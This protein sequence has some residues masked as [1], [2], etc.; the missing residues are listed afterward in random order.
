MTVGSEISPGDREAVF[1]GSV[2]GCQDKMPEATRQRVGAAAVLNFCS[3]YAKEIALTIT[4]E[5]L[6]ALADWSRPPEAIPHYLETARN[7]SA[8]CEKLLTNETTPSSVPQQ[9]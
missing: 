3:C 8:A 1:Q 4:E 9:R 5:Q 2:E 6:E 7:A